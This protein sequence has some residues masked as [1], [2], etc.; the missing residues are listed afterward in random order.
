MGIWKS[1]RGRVSDAMADILG[2][3]FKRI[4]KLENGFSL[5][6][7]ADGIEFSTC[8][9]LVVELHRETKDYAVSQI[10]KMGEPIANRGQ[11]PSV[12]EKCKEEIEIEHDGLLAE[13]KAQV[14]F[15]TP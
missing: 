4:G 14:R 2:E 15:E 7:L 6:D 12:R 5:S 11:L 13:I 1:E 3:L 10:G 9:S 8:G